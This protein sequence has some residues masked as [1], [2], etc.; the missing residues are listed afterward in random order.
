MSS[1]DWKSGCAGCHLASPKTLAEESTVRQSFKPYQQVVKVLREDPG[2]SQ[3]VIA[4][5]AKSVVV[6][7]DTQGHLEQCSRRVVQGQ[8]VRQFQDRA[9]ELWARVVTSL[10]ESTMR[11]AL[12]LVTDRHTAP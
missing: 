2:A 10:P 6:Q 9:A 5:R 4:A 1:G 8:T 7:A 3:K 11:F 12:S